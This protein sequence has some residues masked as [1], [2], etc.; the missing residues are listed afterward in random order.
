MENS[1]L[2]FEDPERTA[3][4]KSMQASLYPRGSTVDSKQRGE[5]ATAHR[6]GGWKDPRRRDKKSKRNR[7]YGAMKSK[8][9]SKEEN[10]KPIRG[11]SG[12]VPDNTRGGFSR[13]KDE[14]FKKDKNFIRNVISGMNQ[15]VFTKDDVSD[16]IKTGVTSYLN[17]NKN[18]SVKD[19]LTK[20]SRE[21]AGNQL[22]STLK[23]TALDTGQNVINSLR[24]EEVSRRKKPSAIKKKAK[25]NAALEK[26]KKVRGL[27]ESRVMNSSSIEKSGPTIDVTATE[28]K[29]KKKGENAKKREKG[30]PITQKQNPRVGEPDGPDDKRTK[31]GERKLKAIDKLTDKRKDKIKSGLKT[32]AKVANASAKVAGYVGSKAKSG[33]SAFTSGYDAK[34]EK[35]FSQYIEAAVFTPK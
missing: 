14:F 4:Y 19:L 29:D 35:S 12:T 1:T 30:G 18:I 5:N 26:L 17:Q 10:L 9:M 31:R 34:E 11:R 28:V 16:I 15:K 8:L 7:G 23:T 24:Q 6:V 33:V 3:D 27:G 2:L 13:P 25:L 20:K 32:G 21:R 22:K